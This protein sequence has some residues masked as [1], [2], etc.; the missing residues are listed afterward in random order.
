MNGDRVAEA[1]AAAMASQSEQ[2]GTLIIA[3]LESNSNLVVANLN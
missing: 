3:N 1:D 2:L